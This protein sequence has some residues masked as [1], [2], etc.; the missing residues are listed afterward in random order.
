MLFKG[1]G[2][3]FCT[4]TGYKWRIAIHEVFIVTDE[5]RD[6]IYGEVTTSKLRQLAIAN[7]FRNMYFDGMQKAIAGVT[8]IEEVQRVTRR[9]T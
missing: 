9:M 4:G 1:K 2:C 5:M 8:T 6:V 3:S 7:N